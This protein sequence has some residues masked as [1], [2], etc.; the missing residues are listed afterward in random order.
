MRWGWERA[1]AV[2]L[3]AVGQLPGGAP[4]MFNGGGGRISAFTP[5]S[6]NQTERGGLLF[7]PA[8]ANNCGKNNQFCPN[9]LVIVSRNQTDIVVRRNNI[10]RFNSDLVQVNGE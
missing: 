3:L 4:A 1:A 9:Q 6:S 10:L 8:K 2:V 7:L 5:N